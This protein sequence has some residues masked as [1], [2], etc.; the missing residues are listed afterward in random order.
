MFQEQFNQRPTNIWLCVNHNHMLKDLNIN[1]IMIHTYPYI[2]G[3]LIKLSSKS[4][5]EDMC[6]LPTSFLSKLRDMMQFSILMLCAK[7]QEAGLCGS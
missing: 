5:R 7:Y 2:C 3:S 4:S 1:P 6:R